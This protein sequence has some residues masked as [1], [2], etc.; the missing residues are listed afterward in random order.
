MGPKDSSA[1]SIILFFLL[2]TGGTNIRSQ[3]CQRKT[4]EWKMAL[5]FGAKF[6]VGAIHI[7]PVQH[8]NKTVNRLTLTLIMFINYHRE[9]NQL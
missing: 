3:I 9:N 1:L 4:A 5:T 7:N 6:E 2:P 8:Q